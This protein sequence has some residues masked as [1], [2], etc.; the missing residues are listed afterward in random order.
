MNLEKVSE[1]LGESSALETRGSESLRLKELQ[2]KHETWGSI[3]GLIAFGMSLVLFIAL[4]FSQMVL[5]GGFITLLGLVL[6]LLAVAAGVMACF[7]AS[8]HSLKQKLAEP[9]LPQPTESPIESP[10]LPQF[11]SVTEQTTKLLAEA[12]DRVTHE[13]PS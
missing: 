9:Q 12:D 13:I 10:G 7:F 2:R 11:A 8:A 4:I 6:I 5:K 1:L 3:A